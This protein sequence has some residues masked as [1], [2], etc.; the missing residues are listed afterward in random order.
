MGIKIITRNK[1]ASFD[2]Q[3]LEKFEAGISLVGTE[4]KVLRLGKA[5][6]NEANVA[7]DAQGEAWVFNMN[8]PHYEFG[9][10]NNHEEARKRK[11]L[12]HKKEIAEL[13]DGV[14]TQGMTI[15][16]TSLYFKEGN[17]K[18]E[19]A[20]AKGKKLHDKRQDQAK[21]DVQ[22]KLQRGEYQ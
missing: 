21:K 19:I 4:V 14:K 15:I 6:I 20:L 13:F 16:P 7:I 2:Y 10:V 18:L 11:L 1:R 22:R 3:L 9:N 12:L 5:S 17:V 8:I